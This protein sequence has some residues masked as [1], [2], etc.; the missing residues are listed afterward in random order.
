M[1]EKRG[2]FSGKVI[3]K[4]LHNCAFVCSTSKPL[5]TYYVSYDYHLV[6]LVTRHVL[7]PCFRN[8]GSCCVLSQLLPTCG[9]S[10]LQTIWEGFFCLNVNHY[11]DV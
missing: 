11:M 3:L 2:G 1:E 4:K 6:G 7:S 8:P 10:W 9:I 5:I